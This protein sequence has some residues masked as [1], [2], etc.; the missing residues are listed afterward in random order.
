MNSAQSRMSCE[1]L[2]PERLPSILLQ[3]AP[4]RTDF[5]LAD[6]PGPSIIFGTFGTMAGMRMNMDIFFHLDESHTSV[7]RDV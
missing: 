1:Y 4:F 3:N 6:R 7:S 2:S 5:D